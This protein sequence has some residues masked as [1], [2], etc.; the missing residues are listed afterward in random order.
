MAVNNNRST[1]DIFRWVNSYPHIYALRP[2]WLGT[3]RFYKIFVTRSMLCGARVAG[4]FHNEESAATQLVAPAELFGPV[5]SWLAGR[6][7]ARRAVQ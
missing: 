1:D 7:V 4:Q 2:R 3:D 6:I 5:M